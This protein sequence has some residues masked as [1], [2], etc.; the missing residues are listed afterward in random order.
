MIT[1]EKKPVDFITISS[2]TNPFFDVSQKKSNNIG[3][4]T[5]D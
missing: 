3:R 1:E 2:E 5:V 4:W